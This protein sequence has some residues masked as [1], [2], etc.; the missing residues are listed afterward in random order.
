MVGVILKT[1]GLFYAGALFPSEGFL[2]IQFS[3]MKVL[4]FELGNVQ[5]VYIV[6]LIQSVPYNDES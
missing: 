1:E 3:I 5:W 4:L 2:N 6:D